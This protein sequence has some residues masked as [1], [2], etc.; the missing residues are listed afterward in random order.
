MSHRPRLLVLVLGLGLAPLASA[1]VVT[2]SAEGFLSRNEVTV[3]AAPADAFT[4]LIVGLPQWWDPQHTYSGDSHNLSI[5]ARPGGCFCERLPGGG[6]VAHMSVINLQPGKLLRLSGAL[7]PLQAQGLT[8][9]LSWAF[10]PV[11]GGTHIVVQYA[12]GGFS[13]D[14]FGALAPGVDAVLS[15][16]LR[17]LAQYAEQA[18]TQH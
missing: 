9:T 3:K 6:G 16:Q 17:R 18:P 7:G 14:G 12:V 15:E 2:V 8:G 10:S 11:A 4:A 13:A 1:G 5:E